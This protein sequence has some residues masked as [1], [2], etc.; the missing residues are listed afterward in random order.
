MVAAYQGLDRIV[1][2]LCGH[3]QISINQQ[4]RNGYTALIKAC[5]NGHD[6]C[7][8]ILEESGADSRIR[9]FNGKTAM[10]HYSEY[11]KKETKEDKIKRLESQIKKYEIEI[12]KR[13]DLINKL[14]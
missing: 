3:P 10:E 6:E 4:D 11:K 8:S 13:K 14:K 7:K 1:K 12:K 2:K 9:D 5:I